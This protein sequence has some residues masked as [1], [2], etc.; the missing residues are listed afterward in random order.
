MREKGEAVVMETGAATLGEI[1]P[2]ASANDSAAAWQGRIELCPHQGCAFRCCDFEKMSHIVLYPG[3]FQQAVA[4]GKSVGHLEIL[5]ANFHGGVRVRC[6]AGNTA[7]CDGGFKPFDCISYPFFPIPGRNVSNGTG[8]VAMGKCPKC[9]LQTT[10]IPNHA[11]RVRNAWSQLVRRNPTVSKWL[12]S[13]FQDQVQFDA[14]RYETT[15]QEIYR[16]ANE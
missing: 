4:E 7:T 10:D 6:R 2:K 15:G 13:V 11:R 8:V 9:P 14:L 3:E 12:A 1:D 5:D 16:D